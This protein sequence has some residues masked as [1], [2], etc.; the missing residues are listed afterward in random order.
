MGSRQSRAIVCDDD[1]IMRSLIRTRLRTLV[2]EVVEAADGLAAWQLLSTE[3]FH[4]ALID[5]NMPGIDG[6]DLIQCLRGHPRT[7]H[8]PIMVLTST[9][10]S[11]SLAR[12]LE[13]GASAYMTKPLTWSV[14]GAQVAHTVRLSIAAAAAERDLARFLSLNAANCQ[15]AAVLGVLAT[16]G[17]E[18]HDDVATKMYAAQRMVSAPELLNDNA[19][20]ISE[21]VRTAF[22]QARPLMPS[23]DVRAQI[24][25][26]AAITCNADAI[27]AA[28]QAMISS[29]DASAVPHTPI[30]VTVT[31][32]GSDI[33][34][35]LG[36]EQF[37]PLQ[38]LSIA[39]LITCG[40]NMRRLAAAC[41]VDL[42]IAMTLIEAHGGILALEFNEHGRRNLKLTLPGH[43]VGVPIEATQS[44]K[45]V[46]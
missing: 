27:V 45:A 24:N 13:V 36:A 41:N 3:T 8:L 31:I 37:A 17:T 39:E 42:A 21:L 29:V 18:K 32:E 2:D 16:R 19:Y 44:I 40:E 23:R 35:C 28:L 26:D 11:A 1:P 7:R 4:I 10:D 30:E 46:A 34:I 20:N 15:F 9:G 38:M 14:F 5:L 6:F 43:R 25:I 22:D 33:A 12:A